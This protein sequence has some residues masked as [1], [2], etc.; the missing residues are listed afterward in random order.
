MSAIRIAILIHTDDPI[1]LQMM[2][3]SYRSIFD[4]VAP[5][6]HI[7]FFNLLLS[8][9]LPSLSNDEQ[10]D[11]IILGG[12]TYIPDPKTA[13]MQQLLAVTNIKLTSSGKDFFQRSL[14]TGAFS[15]RLHEFHQRAVAAPPPGFCELA[16]GC[17]ILLSENE[18]ILTFQGHPEM[19]RELM[20]LL[21][22]SPK[23]RDSGYI[24]ENTD[25]DETLLRRA[26][27]EHDGL[28]IFQAVVKWA[29]SLE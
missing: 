7:E 24:G 6:S 25:M 9:E 3:D 10:Y 14:E 21:L 15:L 4:R 1:P 8:P 27:A 17:Q 19:S 26:E 18:N 13:W 11:L 22:L 28:R 23:S 2:R 20:K 16:E 29:K 5:G 12:G